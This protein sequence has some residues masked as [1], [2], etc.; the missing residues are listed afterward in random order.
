MSAKANGLNPHKCFVVVRKDHGGL[1]I[2]RSTLAADEQKALRIA[3]T[4]DKKYPDLVQ[5][6]QVL[7]TVQV[8]LV[9]DHKTL[10][11]I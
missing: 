5:H 10:K 4:K 11:L 3:Q 8:T 2:D 7:G 6:M 1:F 9:P